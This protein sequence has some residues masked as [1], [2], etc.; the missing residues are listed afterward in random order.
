MYFENGYYSD[1][2]VFCKVTDGT[3]KIGLKKNVTNGGDWA[4]FDNWKLFYYGGDSSHEADGD[5]SGIEGIEEDE[6]VSRTYYTLGG[7]PSSV[8][9]KGVNIVKSVMS[10][11]TV[12]ISK[13]LVK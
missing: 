2:S 7:V 6:V 8:P 9:V 12:R 5:A 1:N 10:D 3:L 4:I 13:I 11:G